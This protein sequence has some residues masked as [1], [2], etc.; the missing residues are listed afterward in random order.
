MI[1]HTFK[2]INYL[3]FCVP[4]FSLCCDIQLE[5][6]QPIDD[7]LELLLASSMSNT[8]ILCYIA[9]RSEQ[10]LK[11]DLALYKSYYYSRNQQRLES[12]IAQM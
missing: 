4:I 9:K 11:L 10:L 5:H 12:T 8:T 2:K 3:L 7:P 6:C 1:L